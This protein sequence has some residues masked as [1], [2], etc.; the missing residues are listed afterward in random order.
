MKALNDH[1]VESL[2]SQFSDWGCKPSHA[3]RLLRE[4]YNGAGCIEPG[5]LRLGKDLLARL[6]AELPLR[7]SKTL[8]RRESVDGTIKLL[9]GFERGG[10]VE[11][12]L[13]PTPIA[14][15]AA[16]CVSSQIGCAMGC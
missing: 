13:M 12:V 11:T 9:L 7:Q 15:R 1:T 8:V 6:N 2:R 4:Y 5:E 3:E 10:A 14:D 16:G